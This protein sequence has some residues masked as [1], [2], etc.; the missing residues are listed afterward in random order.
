[1]IRLLFNDMK[2][3][4]LGVKMILFLEVGEPD[5]LQ[6]P[7]LPSNMVYKLR[8]I[9][10]YYEKQWELCLVRGFK[11]QAAKGEELK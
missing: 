5:E 6:L 1:M 11:I 10:A 4:F 9:D 7:T 3:F 2:D 8:R